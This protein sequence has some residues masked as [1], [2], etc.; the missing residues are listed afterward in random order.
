MTT[1]SELKVR[2]APVHQRQPKRISSLRR[3]VESALWIGGGAALAYY[4]R[5]DQVLAERSSS[6]WFAVALLAIAGFGSVF[7]YLELYLPRKQGRRI[8]YQEWEREVPRTIQLATVLGILATISC[9]AVLWPVF[10]AFSPLLLVVWF[11]ATASA[12]GLVW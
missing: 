9:N 1:D 6:N 8:N 7:L 2:H 4:L 3:G 12:I 5:M 11:M 10:G